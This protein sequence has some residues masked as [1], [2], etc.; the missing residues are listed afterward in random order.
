M[1]GGLCKLFKVI[2][3]IVLGALESSYQSLCGGLCGTVC[4]RRQSA[5]HDIY[6][7]LH[8]HQ[9][10]HIAGTCG[11]VGMQMDRY[12]HFFLEALYERI[13]VVRQQQVCHILDADVVSTHLYQFF[14]QLNE[15]ILVVHGADSVTDGRFADSAVLFGV[16]DGGF[17]I[18]D[19][20][21]CVEYTNY[22]N[23][24]FNCLAAELLNNVI[25]VVLIAQYVLAAEKHL[26]LGVGQSLLKLA[27]PFPGVLV[28]ETEAAVK[29]SAAP[30]LQGVIADAVQYFAG[31][32]HILHPHSGGSLRLVSVAQYGIGY[33]QFLSH[34]LTS[35]YWNRARNTPAAIAEPI[36]PATLG[37]MACMSRKFLGFSF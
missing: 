31:G 6:A 35:Y 1:L 37:P 26:Q 23:A 29:G 13:C 27:Q 18:A 14:S 19:I 4:Q 25:C 24:V 15:V 8:G 22:I 21:E 34:R 33:H 9:V 3:G 20:V 32:K 36:T 30:A 16:L 7:G 11:V 5:V 10:G 2:A 28:E 12:I 17:Q